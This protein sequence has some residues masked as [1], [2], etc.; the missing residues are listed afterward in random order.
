MYHCCIT[1]ACEY[2]IY[3][4][5]HW[6]AQVRLFEQIFTEHYGLPLPLVVINTV[7]FSQHKTNRTRYLIYASEM[8]YKSRAT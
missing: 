1:L 8:I 5:I 4:E 3:L 6:D 7:F 2:T